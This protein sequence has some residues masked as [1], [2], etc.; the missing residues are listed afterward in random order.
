MS[1]PWIDRYGIDFPILDG[2]SR[3][4]KASAFGGVGVPRIYLV[5]DDTLR[6]GMIGARTLEEL[7]AVNSLQRAG[8]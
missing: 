5:R 2:M 1:T 3:G 6:I 8:G 7:E 4:E